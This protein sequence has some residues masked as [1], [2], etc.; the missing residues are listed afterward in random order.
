MECI[1]RDTESVEVQNKIV[2]RDYFTLQL[3]L[4]AHILGPPLHPF[5]LLLQ[6]LFAFRGP[7]LSTSFGTLVRSS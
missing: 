4:L 2:R 7:L 6:I 5:T 3:S 1:V